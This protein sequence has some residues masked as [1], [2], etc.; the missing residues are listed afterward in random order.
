MTVLCLVKV[1]SFYYG[2]TAATY[3]TTRSYLLNY[4][5]LLTQLSAATYLT[6]SSYLP[7]Y[8]QMLTRLPADAYLSSVNYLYKHK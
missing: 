1:R 5:R 2:K 4:P 3:S 6:T 8:L 7:D